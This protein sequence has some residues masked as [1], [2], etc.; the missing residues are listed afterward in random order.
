LLRLAETADTDYRAAIA[1][2][3]N[4]IAFYLNGTQVGV[5]SLATIPTVTTLHIGC[6]F[7]ELEQLNEHV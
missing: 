7:N 4:D 6:D 1:Y 2:K 3:A 5:D